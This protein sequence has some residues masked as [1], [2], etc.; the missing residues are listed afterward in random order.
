MI[1]IPVFSVAMWLIW[2]QTVYTPPRPPDPEVATRR[3]L[4][5]GYEMAAAGMSPEQRVGWMDAMTPQQRAIAME[6]MSNPDRIE[7]FDLMNAEQRTQAMS[8]LDARFR[9][10]LHLSTAAAKEGAVKAPPEGSNRVVSLPYFYRKPSKQTPLWS[11]FPSRHAG[12]IIVGAETCNK[13]RRTTSQSTSKLAVAGLMNTGTNVMTEL[14]NLNCKFEGQKSRTGS[15]DRSISANGP[16]LWQVPWGKH[17]PAE[18]RTHFYAQLYQRNPAFKPDA[19]EVLPVVLVKDAMT[20]M[21]SLCRHAHGARLYR[22]KQS[23]SCPDNTNKVQMVFEANA[24]LRPDGIRDYDS[25]L[26]FW[27]QWNQAY[28]DLKAPRLIVRSED[29]LFNQEKTVQAVC[30]CAGGKIAATFQNIDGRGKTSGSDRQQALER[31]SNSDKRTTKCLRN[32]YLQIPWIATKQ[33]CIDTPYTNKDLEAIRQNSD[34]MK[35]METFGYETVQSRWTPMEMLVCGLCVFL[36]IGCLLWLWL[37]RVYF[38]T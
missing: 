24:T 3:E 21:G 8:A 6:G 28:I 12:P 17:N 22:G 20:W 7:V 1:T 34:A 36:V 10:T 29:L 18:W 16:L 11:V 15:A 9:N 35:I 37:L 4:L 2:W 32:G 38:K 25:P 23:A 27:T 26:D 19:T 14:L 5:T 13:F 33:R 31:Y 30:E